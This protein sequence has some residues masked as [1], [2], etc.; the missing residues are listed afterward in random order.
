LI[1]AENLN[2]GAQFTDVLHE[3]VGKRIVV[4]E[5]ENQAIATPASAL[6]LISAYTGVTGWVFLA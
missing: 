1:V 3:V 4:V 2:F 5:Y 6:L